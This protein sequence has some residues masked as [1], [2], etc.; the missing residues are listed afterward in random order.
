MYLEEQQNFFNAACESKTALPPFEVLKK[1]KSVEVQV[2]RE[3]SVRNGPRA[4]DIDL[5]FYNDEIIDTP[6]LA[7]PHARLRERGFVLRPLF[8]IAPELCDPVTGKTIRELLDAL[9]PEDTP[10]IVRA[11]S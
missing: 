2:G 8:D 9:A 5:L 7:V 11:G 10:V 3:E 6:A 1:I 4:I